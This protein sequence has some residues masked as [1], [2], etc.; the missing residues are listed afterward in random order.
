[1]LTVRISLPAISLSRPVTLPLDILF[2]G[3]TA[4]GTFTRT[5]IDDKYRKIDR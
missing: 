1:M 4:P 5:D 3:D 2:V